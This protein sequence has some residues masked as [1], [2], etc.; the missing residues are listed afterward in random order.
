MNDFKDPEAAS[1]IPTIIDQ[2]RL[3]RITPA[4]QTIF[5]EIFGNEIWNIILEE[6]NRTGSSRMNPILKAIIGV[7]DMKEDGTRTKRTLNIGIQ[8]ERKLRM[9]TNSNIRRGRNRNI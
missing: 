5:S 6:V 3:N 4:E 7:T 2:M 1:L 9:L 8:L